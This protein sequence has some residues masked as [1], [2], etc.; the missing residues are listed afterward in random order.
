[1]SKIHDIVII[2]AGPGGLAAG[3][4]ASEAGKSYLIIEK[5]KR[6]FQSIIDSFPKSKT[7]YPT[8]PKNYTDAYQVEMLAPPKEKVTVEK[9]IEQIEKVVISQKLS[10][11]FEEEFRDIDT[12]ANGYVVKTDKN[13]YVAKNIILAFGSNIPNDLGIYGDAKTVARNLENVTEYVWLP[14]LVI[15]GGNAAA[16]IVAA[17]SRAKRKAISPMPVYWAHRK[18]TFRINKDTSRELG[19]EILLGGQIKILQ[20]AI[21]RI[22]E[23]DSDGVERLFIR[24]SSTMTPRSDVYTYQGM[25]FPMKNVIACIGAHGPSEIFK[26]LRLKQIACT[27]DI[28]KIGHAGDHLLLMYRNL[29]TSRKGIY[30]IGGSI[31]PTYMEIQSDGT[32]DDKKHPNLIYMSINDAKIAVDTILS[33][34]E[35]G[36]PVN[37]LNVI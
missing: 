28:C 30:A 27:G 35:K 23:V 13:S 17:L 9:Y 36:N 22:G 25:S 24:Q 20:E 10:I 29:Q 37:I 1:M 15:G 8:I 18:E 33:S 2:G 26:N 5:G 7:V 11:V 12:D 21:P 3:V 31:S 32:L 4:L 16:D 6:P 34:E 14:T 19:E